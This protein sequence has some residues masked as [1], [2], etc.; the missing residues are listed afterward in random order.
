MNRFH[1]PSRRADAG[2]LLAAWRK[3][4]LAMDSIVDCSIQHGFDWNIALDADEQKRDEN[5]RFAPVAHLTGKE[6]HTAEHPELTP[7][8]VVAAARAWFK[9]NLQ[10]KTILHEKLGEIQATGEKTWKK[11][12]RGLPTDLDKARLIPAIQAVIQHGEYKGR[13]ELDK[14]RHDA[15]VAF[16]HFE[17]PVMLSGKLH[18]VGVS[19]G[20]QPDGKLVYNLNRNPKELLEKKKTPIVSPRLEARG[21]ESLATSN[22]GHKKIVSDSAENSI[23][24]RISA[25]RQRL[26]NAMDADKWITVHP[27]GSKGKGTPAL[28]DGETGEVKAGMGGKFNG[29]KIGEVRR[30][31]SP[32]CCCRAWLWFHQGSTGTGSGAIC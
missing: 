16:H 17:A 12:R 9:Q 1:N 4:G 2:K 23:R 11:V 22:A 26:G 32:L 13:Y 25:I 6:L 31:F 30:G 8:N 15:F 24:D 20:E 7:E 21:T 27:N 3:I 19:V 28:I 10:G 5:G 29:Q 18:S 14:L